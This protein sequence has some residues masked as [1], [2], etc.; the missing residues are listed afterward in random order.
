MALLDG[1]LIEWTTRTP[2]ENLA[3]PRGR[4]AWMRNPSCA[5]RMMVVP[6]NCSKEP[7]M[8]RRWLGTPRP[9]QAYRLAHWARNT[10][11][12]VPHAQEMQLRRK[13]DLMEPEPAWRECQSEVET[14]ARRRPGGW[15]K[16]CL[17]F[18]AKSHP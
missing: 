5:H 14:L 9:P 10:A 8:P 16:L 6:P 11:A 18:G 2:R 1:K 13:R 12:P 15:V 17:W 7:P 3:A 4:V